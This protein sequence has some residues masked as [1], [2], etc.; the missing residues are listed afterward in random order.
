MRSSK[1]TEKDD[2]VKALESEQG[3]QPVL[4]PV[5][6]F[7]ITSTLIV[8]TVFFAAQNMVQLA[9]TTILIAGIL[10]ILAASFALVKKDHERRTHRLL[11]AVAAAQ[12]A[13]IQAE[14]AVREKSRLLATMTHEI[15]TPLNG[16][17]GM[18]GLLQETHLTPEQMNFSAIAHSSS[19]TLLSIVDE[20]LD[21]AKAASKKSAATETVDI[22]SLVETVTE[23]LSPRAHAKA[24]EISAYIASDVPLLVKGDDVHLR[25]I[26]FNLAGNAIK[27]T[28]KG[29]VAIE[30]TLNAK[31]QL[32]IAITDSGIGM[33]EEELGRVFVEYEQA[34]SKTSQKYGGTGL[35]L[36]ISK[37]LI[38]DMGGTYAV[39]SVVGLGTTFS[40]NLSEVLQPAQNAATKALKNRHYML[41]M[42]DGVTKRHLSQ[43]LKDLG[44]DVSELTNSKQLKKHLAHS[45]PL[46]SVICDSSFAKDLKS[47]AKSKSSKKQN[48]IWVMLKS[49]ERS[50]YKAL[51]SEP[52]AGYLLKPLRRST[53]LTLLAA[54]DGAVLKQTS[55]ELRQ[56][57]KQPRAQKSL[58]LLL[59]EDNPV[60]SLLIRTILS[61]LGHDVVTVN[62]GEAALEALSHGEKFDMALLDVE[63]PRLNGHETAR[64]I[65]ERKIAAKGN[66][67]LPI[68]ALTAHAQPDDI[69]ACH[70][71]GMNGHLAKPFDQLD[72]EDALLDLMRIRKSA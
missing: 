33:T 67:A 24:I 65:R 70:D 47:W 55:S 56:A 72:L 48:S 40:F 57:I 5:L 38:A 52:F 58:R 15:R 34:T 69:A 59:A 31:S 7:A 68:L 13:R 14:L 30:V 29:G 16:I 37:R 61:R 6:I 17:I 4:V 42:A 43:S 60:N 25:Q 49:E 41:A 39:S 54:Q 44:A 1:S 53:L 66:R 22:I 45:S 64:V 28:E 10:S 21:N 46:S 51:L 71:A 11:T 27:F 62:N 2:I 12:Q 50:T 18:L 8:F 9:V 23:L 35:G 20:I 32:T 19:R 26:L 36:A 3:A 63:M